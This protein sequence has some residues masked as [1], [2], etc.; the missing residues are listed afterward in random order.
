VV[1]VF[2]AGWYSQQNCFVAVVV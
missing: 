2:F 1:G